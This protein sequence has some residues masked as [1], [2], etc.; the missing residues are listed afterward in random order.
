MLLGSPGCKGDSDGSSVDE[1]GPPTLEF[2]DAQNSQGDV[3]SP[4][5]SQLTLAC[6]GYLTLR[7]GPRTQDSKILDNWIMR[8]PN[9]CRGQSQ[10]GWIRI[11][12]FDEA[13]NELLVS[14]SASPNVV[15]NLEGIDLAAVA[16]TTAV[17]YEDVTGEPY[18]DNADQLVTATWDFGLTEEACLVDNLGGMGG[19]PDVVEEPFG[20]AG[21]M[22]GT[23]DG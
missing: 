2:L 19:L 22:G 21:G 4:D 7:L 16:S 3:Y 1:F 9:T 18:L 20:G 8:P 13:G 10:C 17:L 23:T 15:L 5:E 6:D 12:V 14:N 11:T